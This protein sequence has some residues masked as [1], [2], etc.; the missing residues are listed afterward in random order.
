[1]I[2]TITSLQNDKV[3]RWRSLNRGRADRLSHGLFLAEGEHMAVEALNEAR[4]EALL[5]QSDA[6]DR[7][8]LLIEKAHEIPVYLLPAHVLASIADAKA[9]QGVIAVCRTPDNAALDALRPRIVALDGVQDPGNVGTIL[10]T[11][12]AAAFTGLLLSDACADPF[13]AKA[14][15]ATMGGVFRVPIRVT[16]TLTDDLAALRNNG[17][18]LIAGDLRGESFFDHPAFSKK[19][20]LIVG[21]EGAG[22]SPA[23]LT[24]A[25]RRVR[26]PMPGRAESLNAAVAAGIMIYEILRAGQT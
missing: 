7:F 20:C 4:A 12:D 6:A 5:I 26:L 25:N 16:K 13:G 1:M 18:E 8:A 15:R 2:G 14:L 19:T 11:M 10:R 23:V 24:L 17:F 9:P 22:I 21:N 3:K